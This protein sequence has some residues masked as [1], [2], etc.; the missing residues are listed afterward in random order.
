MTLDINIQQRIDE[1][2][3]QLPL[4]PVIPYIQHIPII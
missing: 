3:N 4:N 2:M 1:V